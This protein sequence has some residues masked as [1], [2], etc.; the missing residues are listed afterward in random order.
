[1]GGACT[2]LICYQNASPFLDPTYTSCSIEKY[3]EKHHFT[4]KCMLMGLQTCGQELEEGW[5][6]NWEEW[7]VV[8]N[9][10]MHE[11]CIA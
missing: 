7:R 1:M 5:E 2:P 6:M 4:A 11:P 9:K 3:N 10:D 8:Y